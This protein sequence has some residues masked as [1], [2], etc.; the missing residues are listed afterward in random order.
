M[1]FLFKDP[2]LRSIFHQRTDREDN[3]KKKKETQKE[4]YRVSPANRVPLKVDLEVNILL[5]LVHNLHIRRRQLTTLV[6]LPIIII[7]CVQRAFLLRKTK[8][9]QKDNGSINL[10]PDGRWIGNNKKRSTSSGLLPIPQYGFLPQVLHAWT[11]WFGEF[12]PFVLR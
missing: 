6:H 9:R 5:D 1:N 11:R 10:P 8:K 7:D 12:P 3:K 4:T 2:L